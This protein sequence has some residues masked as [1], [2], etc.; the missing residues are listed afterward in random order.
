MIRNDEEV[1]KNHNLLLSKIN[2]VI[3]NKKSATTDTPK[4]LDNNTQNTDKNTYYILFQPNENIFDN[5]T[6]P[7]FLLDELSELGDFLTIPHKNRL[8][9]FGQFFRPQ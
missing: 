2:A 6:N 5:G 1:S 7:L 3:A 8:P 9:E 4:I